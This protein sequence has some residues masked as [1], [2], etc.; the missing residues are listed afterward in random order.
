MK[1]QI[2]VN[3]E[4]E[5]AMEVYDAQWRLLGHVEDRGTKVSL[6]LAR[7]RFEGAEHVLP[8][9]VEVR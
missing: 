9:I 7:E 3:V 4:V 1:K 6:E 5:P 8:A 2:A